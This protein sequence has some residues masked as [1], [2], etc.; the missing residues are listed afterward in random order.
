MQVNTKVDLRFVID[1]A[2]WIP[3]YAKENMKLMF[4]SNLNKRGEYVITSER[5]RTQLENLDDALRKLRDAV[6]EAGVLPREPDKETI[7]RIKEYRKEANENRISS[8]KMSS[9]KKQDRQWRD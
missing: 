3:D 7:E 6:R 8:K 2:D 5:Y 4:P 9:R 1:D